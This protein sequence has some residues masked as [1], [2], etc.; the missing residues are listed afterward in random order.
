VAAPAE[1]GDARTARTR[2]S[3]ASRRST[4]A[5]VVGTGERPGADVPSVA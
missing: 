4:A 1:V 2:V 3:G 5:S